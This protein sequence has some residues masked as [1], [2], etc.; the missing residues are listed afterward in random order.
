MTRRLYQILSIAL[1]FVLGQW[2]APARVPLIPSAQ[3][4]VPGVTCNVVSTSI[5]FGNITSRSS[6]IDT[7]VSTTGYL[8]YYCRNTNATA[9][10]VTACFSLGNPGGNIARTMTSS[11]KNSIGYQLYQT[12][13]GT[14]WGSVYYT[15]WGSPESASISI[16]AEGSSLPVTVPIYA[17]INAGQE[18]PTAG[19]YS[20]TYGAGDVAISVTNGSPPC[21]GTTD[22]STWTGFMVTAVVTNTCQVTTNPLA[23]PPKADPSGAIASTT[24]TVSCN[25]NDT[26]YQVGLDNGQN[27]SGS[28]RRMRGGPTFSNYVSYGLYQDP[29]YKAPWGNTKKTRRVGTSS[30]QTFTVYGQ[31]NPGQSA[32]PIGD[33]FDLV[34]VFVYY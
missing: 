17:A 32:T 23:F 14:G 27:V 5:N 2:L 12:P 20:A 10:T 7:N 26:S 34:T 25:G 8:T 16:P 11:G 1:L 24:L 19:T 33:Y 29:S 9:Q 31:V 6:N 15:T 4:A 21:P 18:L 22:A 30:T 13:N 28:T 3:A